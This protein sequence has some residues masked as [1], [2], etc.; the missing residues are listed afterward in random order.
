MADLPRLCAACLDTG[1]NAATPIEVTWTDPSCEKQVGTFGAVNVQKLL[2]AAAR[3]E[4][5]I[6]QMHTP[7]GGQVLAVTAYRGTDL[8]AAHLGSVFTRERYGGDAGR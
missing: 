5:L 6:H 7:E 8:C 1:W 2:E 3:D 4:V